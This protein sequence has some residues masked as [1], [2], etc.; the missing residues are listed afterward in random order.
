MIIETTSLLIGLSGTALPAWLWIKERSNKTQMELE[1]NIKVAQSLGHAATLR[2]HE[3]GAH[4]LRVTYISSLFGEYLGLD[5]IHLR[6][7]MKG[8]FLHDVGKIGIPDNILQKEGPLNEEEWQTMR[9][10]PQLGK[11]LVSQMPWFE[12]AIPVILYHHEK[13]DGSGYPHGLKGDLIPLEAR[14]FTIIDV[15]DAL[16]AVRPYKKRLSLEEAL[17]LIEQESSSHFDPKLLQKFIHLAPDF[18]TIIT[19]KD[20]EELQ[21]LLFARRRKIFGI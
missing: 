3:T 7:L 21:S 11:M 12:D 6:A 13:F 4:N 2:D 17:A 16:L 9:S 5:R 1:Y 8:A 14:I 20:E 18:A 10:H 19:L 15:F